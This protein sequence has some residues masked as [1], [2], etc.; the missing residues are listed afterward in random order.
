MDTILKRLRWLYWIA[1]LDLF[2]CCNSQERRDESEYLDA[3]LRLGYA[4]GVYA[5]EHG[6]FPHDDHGSELALRNLYHLAYKSED[7]L[8]SRTVPDW[9]SARRLYQYANRVN[10]TWQTFPP[11]VLLAER[12]TM[13]QSGNP[14]VFLS[15]GR[16][17]RVYLTTGELRRTELELAGKPWDDVLSIPGVKV[18]MIHPSNGVFRDD[19][20][21]GRDD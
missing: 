3:V 16:L 15:D 17:F 13:A 11:Y 14:L 19:F 6:A 18:S 20:R 4:A 8:L 9:Y 10:G 2:A 12:S 5:E 1:V 7:G 21:I